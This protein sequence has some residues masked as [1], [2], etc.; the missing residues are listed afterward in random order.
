MQKIYLLALLLAAS[1]AVIGQGKFPKQQLSIN[2]F[3]NP[4]IGLEYQRGHASVHAGY[5]VTN[6]TSG[7]TTAF[8]KA[9]ATYW[10][11]PVDDKP[12]PSSFYAGASWLR[13]LTRAYK[14]KNA[15]ALE[16]GFRWYAWKGLNFRLGVIALAA[17]GETLKLNP[18]PAISYSITF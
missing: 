9:G 10:F 11:A 7:V 6:F 2:G 15:V 17:S 13:G 5:Y 8:V 16:T 3:R 18:T 1:G 14:D 12:M 4:S